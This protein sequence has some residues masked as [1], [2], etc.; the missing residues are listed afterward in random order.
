[1]PRT[2]LVTA[3]QLCGVFE[4]RLNPPDVLPEHFNIEQHEWNSFMTGKISE[5][6]FDCTPNLSFT[7]PFTIADI[8]GIKVRIRKHEAK[9]ATGIDRVTYLAI[10]RIFNNVLCVTNPDGYRLIGLECCLLKVLMLLI[11]QHILEWVQGNDV[12]PNTQNGFR[13]GKKTNNNSFI[14][15]CAIEKAWA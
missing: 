15:H 11:N 12:V 13:E 7:Q 14:L 5:T 10:L 1:K 2:V 6:M 3:G 8:K 4:Q 9:S